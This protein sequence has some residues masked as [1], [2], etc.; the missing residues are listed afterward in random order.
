MTENGFPQL[1]YHEARRMR[2]ATIA[3]AASSADLVIW[4]IV[5]LLVVVAAVV[6]L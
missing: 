3:R 2:A 6:A 1:S 4:T 5:A